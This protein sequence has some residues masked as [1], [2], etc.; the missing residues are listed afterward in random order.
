MTE[1]KQRNKKR[2][3]SNGQLKLVPYKNKFILCS[4]P[5]SVTTHHQPER[6]TAGQTIKVLMTWKRGYLKL[7]KKLICIDPGDTWNIQVRGMLIS[8]NDSV[9]E[10]ALLHKFCNTNF[11]CRSS[12]NTD[13]VGGRKQGDCRL[14]LSDELCT[15]LETKLE[16]SL[17]V[18]E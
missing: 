1:T 10:D 8:M 11:S 13:D 9:A 17:F 5:V 3:C 4:N 14:E 6:P 7:Q 16:H 12:F 15:W 18:F 2:S